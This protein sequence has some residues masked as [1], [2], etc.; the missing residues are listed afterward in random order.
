MTCSV[1]QQTIV[2]YPVSA[3]EVSLDV[4]DAHTFI[5]HS[6]LSSGSMAQTSIYSKHHVDCEAENIYYL[7]IYFFFLAEIDL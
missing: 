1:R 2:M 6:L 5:C 3:N 4:S 7:S